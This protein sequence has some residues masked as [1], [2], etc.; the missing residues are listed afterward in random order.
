MSI[1]A[2]HRWVQDNIHNF[3]GDPDSVTIFGESA[4]GASV[5]FQVISPYSKGTQL[6]NLH[7]FC[8][9]KIRI[10]PMYRCIV[11]M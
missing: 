7:Y 10:V 3:G 2:A 4:G 9:I 1:Y 11:P 8:L 6:I 5:D